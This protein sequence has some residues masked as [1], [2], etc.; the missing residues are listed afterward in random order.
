[1]QYV[2]SFERIGIEKGWQR[3]LREGQQKGRQEGILQNAREAVIEILQ[4]R[5]ERVPEALSQQVNT[6]QDLSLL[7]QL[8]RQAITIDSLDEFTTLLNQPYDGS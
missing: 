4:I 2:T 6:I 5:F 7:K 1:M 8:H 3:G